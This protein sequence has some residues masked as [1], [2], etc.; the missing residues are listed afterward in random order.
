MIYYREED[1]IKLQ[2][3]I[4]YNNLYKK[5]KRVEARL[6]RKA[7]TILKQKEDENR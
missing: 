6:E 5:Y 4:D 1:W 7:K 2:Q 3:N